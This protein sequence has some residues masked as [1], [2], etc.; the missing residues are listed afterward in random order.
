MILA[1]RFQSSEVVEQICNCEKQAV[2]MNKQNNLGRTALHY[3]AGNNNT[4]IA[5][6]LL[7]HKYKASVSIEDIE[8]YTPVH[9]ACKYGRD[10]VLDELIMLKPTETITE[11]LAK[12]TRDEKTPLLVAKC[13]VNYSLCNIQTL[14]KAGANI[15]EVDMYKNT[16]LHLYSTEEDDISVYDDILDKD[17]SLLSSTNCNLETPLHIAA[18][19]GHSETC[20]YFIEE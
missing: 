11:L 12:V 1:T 13:A 10:E 6:I 9:T 2:E 17:R 7:N 4:K 18:S 3:A 16:V 5:K 8:G 19:Y 20:F 14:I 15:S